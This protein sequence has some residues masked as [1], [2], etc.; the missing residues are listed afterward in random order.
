MGLHRDFTGI[1]QGCNGDLI[2]TPLL[3]FFWWLWPTEDRGFKDKQ[4]DQLGN[5][6]SA[7]NRNLKNDLSQS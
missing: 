5:H 6:A 2:T 1:L 4:K 7:G 3:A